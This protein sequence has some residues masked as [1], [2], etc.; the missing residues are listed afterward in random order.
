MLTLTKKL[1]KKPF[2][3]V[4]LDIRPLNPIVNY[5][6]LINRNIKTV[7]DVGANIGQFAMMIHKILPDAAIFS[8]EPIEECYKKLVENMSKVPEFSAL[9]YA[10]GNTDIDMEMYVNEHTTSSSLL[11]MANL[12]KE[13]FPHTAKDKMGM[14]KV[15]QLDRVAQEFNFNDNILVK[16]DV[17]GYEDKVIEGGRNII[18]RAEVVIIETNFKTL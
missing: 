2:N 7:F 16:I 1:L 6:W 9:N 10:L 3:L 17:Q 4:G 18:S 12:H 15:K 13:A 5:G 14:T 11:P 8:F